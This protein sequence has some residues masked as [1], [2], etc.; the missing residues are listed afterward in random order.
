MRR[1]AG[2]L[3]SVLVIYVIYYDLNHGTLRA[4]TEQ[5]LEASTKPEE[6]GLPYFEKKVSPGETV[7]SIVEMNLDGPIPVSIEDVVSDFS[8]LNK[9]TKPQEIKSGQTYKFPEYNQNN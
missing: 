8:V 9:G 1:I 6:M 7:L 3:L 5:V 2:I 4:G